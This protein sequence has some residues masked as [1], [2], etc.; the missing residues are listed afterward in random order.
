MRPA[1]ESTEEELLIMLLSW[2]QSATAVEK[3]CS[4]KESF[5]Q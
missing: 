1:A 4:K 3:R 5:V 2:H